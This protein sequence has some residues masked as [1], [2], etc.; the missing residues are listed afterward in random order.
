LEW[1]AAA[2]S[3]LTATANAASGGAVAASPVAPASADSVGRTECLE[4]H[5]PGSA[6]RREP[7]RPEELVLPEMLE[8]PEIR[9]IREIE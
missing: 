3:G 1:L 9:E 5:T 7:E 2:R 8:T 4:R 6:G